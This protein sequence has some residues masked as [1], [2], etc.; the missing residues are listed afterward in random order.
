MPPVLNAYGQPV[1]EPVP[2]WRA[3]PLPLG[4][5]LQGRH[6]R[7]EPL[8]LARH[9]AG[10]FRA[11]AQA[12]DGRDWTYLAYGPFPD[13]A[14]WR[15]HAERLAGSADPLHFAVI[16]AETGEPL[17]TLA[18]MRADATNGVIEVG[19][20]VFSPA[21][22]GSAAS[23]EAQFLLMAHVF[24]TLRYRRY[25]WKCDSLNAPSRRAA[26]RL[27]FTLEGIFRQAV[28]YKGRNRDTAWYSVTD[29]E[30]PRLRRAFRLWLAPENFDPQGR[31]INTLPALRD[32]GN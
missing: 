15:A 8:N 10:L 13:E 21:L 16:G 4:V 23:T 3:R 19:H 17:G 7:L 12:S 5:T 27:G 25:E 22:Q 30:W 2:G 14:A 20:V 24:E 1:G 31:Q 32:R 26:T 11:Y 9:A 28:I 18:L 6:C 29:G